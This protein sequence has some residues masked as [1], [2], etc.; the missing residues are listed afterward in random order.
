MQAIPMAS[1]TS[2]DAEIS[3]STQ[4][5]GRSTFPPDKKDGD[6]LAVN[7]TDA[8]S[9]ERTH[10]RFGSQA[11]GEGP[12]PLSNG[13]SLVLLRPSTINPQGVRYASVRP[14]RLRLSR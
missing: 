7:Q 5:V 6:V 4:R 9:A 8:A 10:V 14:L 13:L 12:T 1:A 11:S 2:T 3:Q